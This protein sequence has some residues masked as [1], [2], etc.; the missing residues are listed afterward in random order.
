MAPQA[1]LQSLSDFTDDQDP[2]NF[3]FFEK[4]SKKGHFLL[5]AQV[6]PA[7]STT[8][9]F[10]YLNHA[11]LA[12]K[13]GTQPAG[14]TQG[15]TNGLSGLLKAQSKLQRKDHGLGLSQLLYSLRLGQHG[16][17]LFQHFGATCFSGH[18]RTSLL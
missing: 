2:T 12:N 11:T 3:G 5:A 16:F 15:D 9:R 7:A 6:L 10:A 13:S 17:G 14:P 18:N 1:F 8:R 4:W